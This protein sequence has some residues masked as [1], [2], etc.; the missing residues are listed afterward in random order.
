MSGREVP[1]RVEQRA[2]SEAAILDTAWHEFARHGPDGS[3]LR[4]ITAEA[5][6]SVLAEFAMVMIS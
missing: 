5:G 6:Y 3:S 4:K 1:T 2:I